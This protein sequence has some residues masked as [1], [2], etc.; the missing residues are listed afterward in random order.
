MISP[1]EQD[2]STTILVCDDDVIILELICATLQNK[3]FQV[4]TASSGEEALSLCQRNRPE[5]LLLDAM[6]PEMDG[7]QVCSELRSLPQFADLPI[8]IITARHDNESVDR[9]F[10]VGAEEYITKPIH[11]A[12]LE[13]RIR[14]IL[15]R[16]KAEAFVR[17][18]LHTEQLIST[19]LKGT[20][21]GLTL[22]EELI[23][24][25][26]RI[27]ESAWLGL[28]G[29]GAIFFLE[30]ETEVLALTAHRGVSPHIPTLCAR[31]PLGTCLCGQAA[32]SRLLVFAD[33]LDDRHTIRHKNMIDHGCYCIP[34]SGGGSLFGVMTFYIRHK[35]PFNPQLQA[36]LL[37]IANNLAGIIDRK[38]IEAAIEKSE[39]Q[40]RLF[41]R[42]TP[43]AVAMFD[44][45]MQYLQV[46]NRWKEVYN[47]GG[48][49]IIGQSHYEILPDQPQKWQEIHH[50]CLNGAWEKNDADPFPGPDN[51]ER[52]FQWEA[53]PWLQH[54]GEI[55]GILMFTRDITL[56]KKMEEE[57]RGHRDKLASEQELIEDIITRMRTT[58]RF[59][60]KNLRYIQASPDRTAGDLLLSA[61]RPEGSQ[62]VMLGDVTGHG[63]PAAVCGPIAADIFY[64]MTGK[65]LSMFEIISEINGRLYEKTPAEMFM[66]AGFMELDASRRRGRIWNCSIP[67]ILIYHNDVIQTRIP[68][69]LVPLGVVPNLD[70][71]GVSLSLVPGDRIYAYSDGFIEEN[72][73]LGQ[74]YGQEN[75]EKLIT[76][77]IASNQSLEILQQTVS[78]FRSGNKQKDDTTMVEVLC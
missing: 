18:S 48:K 36:T 63:L 45:E 43:A 6:M 37:T 54:T 50:R 74:M 44:C 15:K 66:A 56:Q 75:L 32:E 68:S 22:R 46:S 61:F 35:T 16:R 41:M 78:M 76:S 65:G 58:K 34:I 3:G 64:A 14:V 55:G 12:V 29:S 31:V 60:P 67:E 57:I 42:H 77:T 30:P 39:A 69:S 62:H 70:D 71:L 28:E 59:D 13:H 25:L 2:A 38:M 9:A 40:I 10:N 7:F 49:K 20:N 72:N 11:W 5:L 24:V 53:F 4:L 17:W 8:I 1:S 33:R 47:L 51:P 52:W 73:T 21:K 23:R 26:D 19:L 27:L